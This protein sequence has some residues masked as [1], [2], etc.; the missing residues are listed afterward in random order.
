VI[1]PRDTTRTT[2]WPGP[3]APRPGMPVMRDRR[4]VVFP[5]PA[6][7]A[8]RRTPRRPA[9]GSQSSRR[10]HA[11]TSR[12]ATACPGRP[13][14]SPCRILWASRSAPPPPGIALPPGKYGPSPPRPEEV[15]PTRRDPGFRVASC[16]PSAAS[17]A[18]AAR[19]RRPARGMTCRSAATQNQHNCGL[20]ERS[21]RE[22][23]GQ[24]GTVRHPAARLLK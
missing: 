22:Q 9:R 6:R 1:T 15:R 8:G 4:A 10:H 5:A 19:C 23:H 13:R 12:A 7:R 2:S 21:T 16:R 24:N 14:R 20:R 11:R 3:A 17:A 18:G